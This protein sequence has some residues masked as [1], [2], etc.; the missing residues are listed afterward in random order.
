M[1]RVVFLSSFFGL[2]PP[3]PSCMLGQTTTQREDR[4]GESKASVIAEGEGDT[5][6]N[7]T[8][9]KTVSSFVT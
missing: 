8:T 3:P 2:S 4:I 9:E 7:N 5:E 1:K 6:P